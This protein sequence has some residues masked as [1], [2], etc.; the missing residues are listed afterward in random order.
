MYKSMI[1]STH[2]RTHARM[3]T[4]THTLHLCHKLV[5]YV[6]VVESL[7]DLKGHSVGWVGSQQ[8]MLH[9]TARREGQGVA[10]GLVQHRVRNAQHGWS[11]V[12]QEGEGGALPWT[13]LL[14]TCSLLMQT[15]QL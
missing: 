14:R 13:H 2:A 8:Y 11:A 10:L 1:V 15:D 7:P 5:P 9:W 3:H 4:H 12:S 6:G